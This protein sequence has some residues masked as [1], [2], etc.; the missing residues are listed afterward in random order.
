MA[1][2]WRAL[3]LLALGVLL[4]ASVADLRVDDASRALDEATW[5]RTEPVVSQ[6]PARDEAARLARDMQRLASALPSGPEPRKAGLP[7]EVARPKAE[8]QISPTIAADA[9]A[10][11]EARTR[12]FATGP[13][14]A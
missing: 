6:A 13:P 10:Y 7:V 12:P 11:A 14:T 8:A 1:P 2:T 9:P 4:S 3:L 5:E